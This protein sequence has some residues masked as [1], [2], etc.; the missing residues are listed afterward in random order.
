M[1]VLP[2]LLSLVRIPLGVAAWWWSRDPVALT[3]LMVVAAVSDW[4]D[5]GMARWMRRGDTAAVA[6]RAEETGAWLD[7]LC[8][9]IFV[10]LVLAALWRDGVV[11]VV[12]LALLGVRELL[13]ALGM[14]VVLAAMGRGRRVPFRA[15]V[16][17]K[18][19]TVVQFA[20]V[21][22]A[23]WLP[24]WRD[25]LAW[26]AAAV[27]VGAAADYA[28]RARRTWSSVDGAGPRPG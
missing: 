23:L 4:L 6:T 25:G 26:L 7:P 10:L 16:L 3:L 17:G 19:T 20:A 24:Q 13:L 21:M 15:R 2:T 8:D 5:G 18:A 1:H 9:K 28:V 11:D 14:L 22:A 12:F 27:G